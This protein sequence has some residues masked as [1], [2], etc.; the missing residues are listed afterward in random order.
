MS[1]TLPEPLSLQSGLAAL[2]LEDLAAVAEHVGVQEELTSKARLLA[3]IPERLADRALV[4]R[5]VREL[6]GD[7]ATALLVAAAAEKFLAAF[8]PST[9]FR[10][11][12]TAP[13]RDAV[14]RGLLLPDVATGLY[15]PAAE[16]LPHIHDEAAKLFAFSAAEA[17][18]GAVTLEAASAFRDA[19]ACW[20]Y[21]IKNPITLTQSGATPKRTLAKVS[22]LLEVAEEEAPLAP[23]L[24]RFGCGR[25]E[26]LAEDLERRGALARGDGELRGA[27]WLSGDLERAAAAFNAELARA[28]VEEDET[29]GAL[30]AAYLWALSPPGQ[31]RDAAGF[32]EEAR[33]V[34]PEASEA[35]IYRAL[36]A[37]FVT[38]VAAAG[39]GEDG[40]LR[41]ARVAEP[42][43]L[44]TPPARAAEPE[45]LLGGNF[46]LKVPHDLPTDT[47]LKLEAFAEQTGGGR[48]LSYRISKS[49]F[50]RALD[51]GVDV[52][53]VLAFLEERV[54]RPVPQNV[55]FSLRDWA[56]QYGTISF[57]DRLVVAADKAE[58]A[59]EVATLP[60]VAPYVKGRR[61]LHAVE[62]A[63]K[64]YA[65]VRDALTAAGYLPRSLR[66]EGE[67]GV[68]PRALFDA[69]SRQA[70]KAP[71]PEPEDEKAAAVVEFA[72]EHGRPV[73][74]WLE[75]EAE[76]REVKPRKITV[77]RGL[78]YLHVDGDGGRARIPLADV[79]R[80]TFA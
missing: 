68:S 5:L 78:A 14:A 56:K 55:A 64:D 52:D 20:C 37:L 70:G 16:I 46:E 36:C 17:P 57:Y 22:P 33:R 3:S 9:L 79:V 45:F 8:G 53:E 34:V 65:A 59:D 58:K 62:I 42:E 48:F 35:A 28:A 69:A 13:P 72:V 80:A 63:R 66:G 44:K 29:A 54:S 7:A 26:L 27:A 24:E 71:P 10:F 6:E 23:I 73:K 43:E 61:E 18:P 77:Y 30:I 75:G 4:R 12:T 49:T 38:G 21:V 50:Y 1:R 15:R 41:L 60:A 2:E 47:R 51:A 25:L 67:A 32:V 19:V 74:L 76:P 39:V 40:V 11:G 31:W